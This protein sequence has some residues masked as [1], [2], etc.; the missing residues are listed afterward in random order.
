MSAYQII[1]TS[2]DFSIPF[3]ER[4]EFEIILQAPFFKLVKFRKPNSEEKL[5]A[6]IYTDLPLHYKPLEKEIVFLVAS[7]NS[8]ISNL[9]VKYSGYCI[10][11]TE[12][13]KIETY[14][15]FEGFEKDFV[16]LCS[17]KANCFNDL[18]NTLKGLVELQ[19]NG[20]Y[21]LNLNPSDIYFTESN[22][23]KFLNISGIFEKGQLDLKIHQ[24]PSNFF[25]P[26]VRF[27]NFADLEN[28]I[29]PFKVGSFSFGMIFLEVI[30]S[31]IDD[32]K[33]CLNE[34]EFTTKKIKFINQCRAKLL[35][36]YGEQ[37]A[38]NDFIIFLTTSLQN[39]NRADFCQLYSMA[40]SSLII[41]SLWKEEELKP[42][43][44]PLQ[45]K[46]VEEEENKSSD[47]DKGQKLFEKTKKNEKLNFKF[48]NLKMDNSETE[49]DEEKNMKQIPINKKP[50]PSKNQN[51]I[52]S[53]IGH[54]VSNDK[55]DSLR[56]CI[57]F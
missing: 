19:T 1:E 3:K 51:L 17:E 57:K 4:E 39:C 41:R 32:L 12:D 27:K 8:K 6:K 34:L 36:L 10:F 29:D 48:E 40:L 21:P 11:K 52:T 13:N 53:C 31:N 22:E 54:G 45:K 44:K 5:L 23:P 55:N 2:L 20:V 35:L 7:V 15:V 26:E 9:L 38:I 43:K 33:N 37:D 18:L 25:P 47:I 56:K 30:L 16:S 50:S 49:E 46:P 24:S 14:L 42:E 28:K